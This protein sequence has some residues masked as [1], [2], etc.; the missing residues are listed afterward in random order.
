MKNMKQLSLIALLTIF[1][2][3]ANTTIAQDCNKGH[4]HGVE[5]WI[6]DLTDAQKTEIKTLRTAH[7]KE[8]QQ[9]KNQ[10][11]IKR[12][13]LKALQTVEN[14]DMAAINK[15][16]EERSALRTD[17]EKKS[18]AHKQAV[19]KVLTEEQRVVYDS[20]ISKKGAHKCGGAKAAHKCGGQK[21]GK[22]CGGQTQKAPCNK[23]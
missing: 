2:F 10:M 7:R 20:K 5:S 17:L 16:I 18:A 4:K 11:D 8:V 22:K 1:V 12:A 13:E 23:N 3:G 19:R 21:D 6:P 9:V 14:P 15:K